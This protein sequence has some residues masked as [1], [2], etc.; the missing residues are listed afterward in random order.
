MDIASTGTTYTKK[1]VD[2]VFQ[3][4]KIID[5]T[6]EKD[7]P[8]KEKVEIIVEP[9]EKPKKEKQLTMSDFFEELKL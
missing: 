2:N 7:M 4:S 3:V 6:N 5:I 9:E 1:N 8:K